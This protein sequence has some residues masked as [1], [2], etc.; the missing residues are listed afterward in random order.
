M[1]KPQSYTNHAMVDP[2]FHYV[3]IP[4]LM[5]NL[6][7]SFV[8]YFQFRHQHPFLAL[9]WIVL[10]IAFVLMVLKTRIYTL[11]VQDRVIRLEER[12]RLAAL[13]PAAEQ[14][15]IPSFTTPQLIALRF[16]SD[17]E[18]PALARRALSENLAPKQIKQAVQSWRIDHHRA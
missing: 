3:L 4:L 5:L 10:S 9:W 7:F 14:F 18:L 12:A 8:I 1:P 2:L 17:A 16:A 6:I 11:R 13:L 15:A